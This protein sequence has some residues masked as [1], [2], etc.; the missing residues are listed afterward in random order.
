MGFNDLLKKM[1]GNKSQRDLKEI[2]PYIQ[3]IKAISPELEKLTN[4]ELR[5]RVDVVKQHIQDT[6]APDR[7][8]VAELKEHVETLD[9]DK[10]ESTWEEIDKIEKEILKKIEKVLDE[11]LPEVFAIVKETARRFCNNATIEVTANDFDRSLAVDHD[12][13]HIEGDKAIYVNH[14]MAGGNEVVWDMVHYDVQLI[15]GVVLHKGK[16]AEMATGEGKTLVATL[17]VFLNALS[18]NGVH[19]VT[20]NDYLSKR[21][22]E[23]MGPLYMFHGLSVDC[24][25]KHE[26]NSE[27][28]RNA[29]NADITF[30]TNN[31]FGFDYLRDNMASSPLDL[32]QRMHNYAIVDEVDSVLIDDARTPLIISG[33]TPK[34]DDQMFEQFQPKVEELVKMQRTLITKLLAEAKSKIASDDKK[35]REEGAVLLYRCFKGLPKNGALIKYLSEPGIKPLMLETEA[36]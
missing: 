19:V 16:I 4:D 33:P 12:F 26:P 24:I 36:V 34:G 10:R 32:V 31:E 15:G 35:T 30:G 9:Y 17:P 25:D 27:A 8:R 5:H 18:G 20:V 28:R 21:D 23:W 6:V 29:Y 14:W 22:S 2:E 7:Q 11:S 13:V 3:K 1:F